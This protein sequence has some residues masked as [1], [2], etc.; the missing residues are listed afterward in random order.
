MAAAAAFPLRSLRVHLLQK[1]LEYLNDP[2][3]YIAFSN[4]LPPDRA[5]ELTNTHHIF[6]GISSIVFDLHIWP[7]TLTEVDNGGRIIKTVVTAKQTWEVLNDEILR[8]SEFNDLVERNKVIIMGSRAKAALRWSPWSIKCHSVEYPSM[9]RMQYK[10][11]ADPLEYPP[12]VLLHDIMGMS[13]EDFWKLVRDGRFGRIAARKRLKAA[14]EPVP[15]YSKRSRTTTPTTPRQQQQPLVPP[16]ISDDDDIKWTI[17]DVKLMNADD[18]MTD[19][20]WNTIMD[21]FASRFCDHEAYEA[22]VVDGITFAENTFAIWTD[23]GSGTIE[24]MSN[25]WNKE[26]DWKYPHRRLEFKVTNYSEPI[27]DAPPEEKRKPGL[28]RVP[29]PSSSF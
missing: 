4:A 12:A 25:M 18:L 8:R 20:E 27:F 11:C 29:P 26:N 17:V 21:K 6:S 2:K 14:G 7:S 24:F 15:R 22:V 10:K 9:W 1:W 5:D 23:M 13:N 28:A 19:A 16:P 3:E